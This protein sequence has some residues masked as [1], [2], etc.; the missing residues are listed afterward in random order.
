MERNSEKAGREVIRKL[1]AA[2]HE[3]YFAGGCVRDRL[4]GVEP[5]DHDVATS[6]A[7]DEVI[8]L[9]PRT[10][11]VGKAFG[12]ILV[13]LGGSTIEVATFRADGRYLDG[14]RPESV[15]FADL[16]SDVM[17]RDFTV[18]GMMRDPETDAVI[19]LVGGR[20]DLARRRIRAI[21]DPRARFAEDH[22]RLVRAI[23]FACKLDFEIEEGTLA[24]VREMAPLV[25]TVSGERIRNELERILATPRAARG[26]RLLDETGLLPHVLPEATGDREALELGIETLAHLGGSGLELGLAA[27]LTARGNPGAAPAIAERLHLS[28]QERDRLAWLV[29]NH[30]APA[31]ALEGPVCAL[32]RLA[33]MPDFPALLELFR[34]RSLAAGRG[35]EIHAR[36]AARVAGWSPA[37]LSPPRLLDG[38]DLRAL[39]LAPGPRYAEILTALED[40][41]LEGE[42]RTKEAAL[43]RVREMIA[44]S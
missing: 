7:P 41:Q 43:A 18:N 33:R 38:N 11:P 13:N 30:D 20:E 37:E 22:L 19:D 21:G 44:R 14:R 35:L 5:K 9:F 16:K 10:V 2:G 36:L 27:L 39:G 25:A 24:A 1:R 17:R 8:R 28:R 40:A 3:A 31:T 32:K 26:V 12:V 29:R 6:A 42:L 15:T 23:R 34:A 4:M